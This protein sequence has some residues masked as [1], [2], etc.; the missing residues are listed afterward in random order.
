MAARPASWTERRV[1]RVPD[2]VCEDAVPD[3]LVRSDPAGP[4]LGRR[5][6]GRGFR[7]LDERGRPIADA[8]VVAR[9][10]A[11]VLPPAWEDVWICPD[12]TGHI[13]A[14]GTDAAGR[15]Q[16]RYHDEWTRCRDADKYDRAL[17]LGARMATVRTELRERLAVSGLGARR[18][19]AGGVRLLDIG[20]FRSGGEQYAPD[21]DD[22]GTFGLATLR[23]EHVRLRRGAVLFCY[24]AKGDVTRTVVVRDRP[25]HRLVDGLLRR[26]GGGD[27]LLAYRTGD[28]DWHDVRA[29]DLNAAVKELI[30]AHLERHRARGRGAGPARRRGRRPAFRPTSAAAGRQRDADRRRA[31]GQHARRRPGLLRRPA[32]DRAVRR[33]PHRAADVAP[34]RIHRHGRRRRPRR[35]RPRGRAADPWPVSAGCRGVRNRAPGASPMAPRVRRRRCGYAT[36]MSGSELSVVALNCTLTPSPGESS[37]QKLLDEVLAAL[38]RQATISAETVRLVDLDIRPGVEV[39]MGKGDEWPTVRDHVRAADVLLVATPT[40][41]GHMSS[42]AQRMLERLDAELSETDDAGR[43]VMFGKVAVVAVVGNE[44]GAHKVVADM[45]QALNDIGFSLPAQG[46]VYWNGEAMSGTD[47]KDLEKTPDAVASTTAT[48]AAN[49]VHLAGLLS[50]RQYPAAA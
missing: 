3:G 29:E 1:I 8:V 15:R 41:L 42:V 21:E 49:A 30:A 44:D 4:G 36:G 20:V 40:W 47:Y 22:D 19:L 35:D 7:Y 39:D 23:R 18:V 17:R 31:T 45:Q 6:C 26:Q 12:P 14:V 28:R 33:G 2:P 48:L 34:Q 10:K 9:V 27:D 24:P 32:G 38:A 46:S 37:S 43:P 25:V 11:L 13:Q 16:Y 50:G 5:R